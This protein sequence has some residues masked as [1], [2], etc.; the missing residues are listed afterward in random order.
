MLRA[1]GNMAQKGQLLKSFGVNHMNITL[2][3]LTSGHGT[4]IES[5]PLTPIYMQPKRV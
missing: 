4:L 2:E 5:N 1:N 3:N